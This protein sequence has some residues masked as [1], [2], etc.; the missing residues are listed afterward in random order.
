MRISRRAALKTIA[1]G[2]LVPLVRL[3]PE[4]DR[5]AMLDKWQRTAKRAA[6]KVTH[7]RAAV[8]R[9]ANSMKGSTDVTA[10][11]TEAQSSVG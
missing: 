1:A 7:Y 6:K 5:E 9:T 3:R 10:A 4:I 11:M 2:M 8:R